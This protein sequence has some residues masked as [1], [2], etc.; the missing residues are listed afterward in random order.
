LKIVRVNPEGDAEPA[1]A[2]KGQ[3]LAPSRSLIAESTARYQKPPS[4]TRPYFSR[5]DI[6][7]PYYTIADPALRNAPETP[8]PLVSS[9]VV[10]DQGV[11]VELRAVVPDAQAVLLRSAPAET[12]AMLRPGSLTPQPAVIVPPVSIKLGRSNGTAPFRSKTD[13]REYTNFRTAGSTGI[14]PI[15]TTSFQL[16]ASLGVDTYE[17]SI[18]GPARIGPSKIPVTLHA[19]VGWQVSA[20]AYNATMEPV[21]EHFTI[22]PGALKAGEQY[23]LTAKATLQGSAYAE[24]YR[25]VGYPGIPYTNLY[26]PATYRAT[27]VDVHTAPDL[28]VAYLPGT[29]DDVPAY[30]PDLGVTPT[31]LTLADLT[32]AKLAQYDA[33]VLGVRAYAAH[34]ELA[35]AGSQPLMEYAKNGGVVIVQY[36]TSRYGD[37]DAPFAISVPGSAEFNVVVEE[38]P[39]T[40]LVPDSLVFTWPN[41]ITSADFDHWVA[42][43]GHGF[44]RS[45]GAEFQPLLETHD[46]GQDEEKGGLLVARTGKGYYIYT[47]LALYRQLPEGVPGAYRLFANLISLGKNPAAAK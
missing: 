23:R 20:P 6:E 26:T 16:G 38:A 8:A 46:P 36:N 7:Q 11:Q 4:P 31:V 19:P 15:G 41:R 40:L 37:G 29:G 24:S 35:G 44:A 30:L 34:P 28:K 32:A 13:I 17:G 5:P 22:T 9:A 18:L 14:I 12:I 39:V 3:A 33:V 2:V 1:V 25:P 47:A 10:D 27:A 43:R 42:E 21:L 45:W